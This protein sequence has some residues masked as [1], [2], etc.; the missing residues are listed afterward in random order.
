LSDD[1]VRDP[2]EFPKLAKLVEAKIK[3]DCPQVVWKESFALLGEYDLIDIIEAP[4]S[5]QVEK[6]ALII[7][8]YGH[9]TTQTM[10]ATP[11]NSFLKAMSSKKMS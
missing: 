6:A 8:G 3:K 11:W 2:A 4:N 1:A 7:R 5:E 9:A 10:P